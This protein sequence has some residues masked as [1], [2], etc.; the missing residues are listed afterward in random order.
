MS[1]RTF[2]ALFLPDEPRRLVA[3]FIHNIR[4]DGDGVKWVA[5]ELLHFTLRFFG[6]LE[7]ESVERAKEVT[8]RVAAEF[9]PIPVRIEGA[10]TF[11]PGGKPH[12]YWLGLTEGG[13]RIVRLS[14]AL[15]RGYRDARLGHADKPFRPH[16]TIGRAGRRRGPSIPPSGRLNDYRGLT[17][18]TPEFILDCACVVRSDLSPHGP[19]YTPLAEALLSG[20]E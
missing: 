2:T 6:D 3:S 13:D 7:E 15:E 5:P 4:S 9:A 20:D 8:T 12:V 16:L 18:V 19:T 14:R 17:F 11:P 10:G 1:I